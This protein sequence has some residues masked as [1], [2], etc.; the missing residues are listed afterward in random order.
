MLIGYARVSTRD[1]NPDGHLDALV[2]AGVEARNT[3][4]DRASGTLE[5][6]PQFDAALGH[7][8]AGDVLVVTKLDRMARSVKHLCSITD[9]RVPGT[10]ASAA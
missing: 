8:R 1:Q 5:Q 10:R 2:A 9:R 4:V 6:R 7:L 3:Y